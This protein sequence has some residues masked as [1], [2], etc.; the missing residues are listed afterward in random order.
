MTS[1]NDA[2]A[3]AVRPGAA[4]F[5]GARILAASVALIGAACGALLFAVSP[6]EEA[7]RQCIRLT[8]ATSG[9]LLVSVFPAAALV[10]RWPSPPT[11]WLLRNRR[12]LG[13]SVAASHVG[14]HGAFIA[15][16]YALGAGGDTG[17]VVVVGGGFGLLCLAVMAATSTDAAQR[18]LGR[19]WRRLHLFAL[20]S[21]WA[22]FTFSYLPIALEGRM[23]GIVISAGLIGGLVLRWLPK[24]R[25]S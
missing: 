22:I 18:R 21:A 1:T 14:F 3:A 6:L 24:P 17:I 13:L 19:H 8:A 23:V 11:R 4:G 20:Y 25:R 12:Y 15:A 16:L 9:V 7:V 5:E 2:T 10:R